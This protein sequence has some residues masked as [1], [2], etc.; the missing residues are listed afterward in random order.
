M[1]I[2]SGEGHKHHE[3][4]ETTAQQIVNLQEGTANT[5]AGTTTNIVSFM[6]LLLEDGR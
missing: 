6:Q 4:E 1:T 2:R 3:M 5:S